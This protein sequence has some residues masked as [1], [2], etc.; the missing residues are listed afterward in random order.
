MQNKNK[1]PIQNRVEI[2]QKLKKE[3]HVLL[4]LR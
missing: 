2:P 3:I 1:K 4:I